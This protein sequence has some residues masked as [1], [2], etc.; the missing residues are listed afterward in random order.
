MF[1]HLFN[2]EKRGGPLKNPLNMGNPAFFSGAG[3]RTRTPNMLIT[4]QL[5]YRLSYAG[6]S[7]NI[8][9]QN[10]LILKGPFSL[11]QRLP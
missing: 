10:G 5:L 3:K 11:F 8:I 2:C 9:T 6:I 4:I 1:F 7:A